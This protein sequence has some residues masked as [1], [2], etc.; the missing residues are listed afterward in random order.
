MTNIDLTSKYSLISIPASA[1]IVSL[2]SFYFAIRSWMETNRPIVVARVTTRGGGNIMTALDLVVQN[3][4]NRP[5]K[6]IRLKVSSKKLNS[7]LIA[8]RGTPLRTAIEACFSEKGLI[9]IL[10]HNRSVANSFGVIGGPDSTWVVN[11]KLNVIIWYQGLGWRWFRNKVP[12][13]IT[14]DRGFAG[15]FWSST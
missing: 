14:D 15:S 11:S 2:L 13:L 1:L 7:I 3:V 6:N 10:E 5:A 9:P 8:P 4:G 12:L